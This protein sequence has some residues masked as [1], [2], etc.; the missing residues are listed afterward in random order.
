M[1]C[2]PVLAA[3]AA[4]C[5]RP[6]PG[7]PAALPADPGLLRGGLAVSWTAHGLT[8]QVLPGWTCGANQDDFL[9]T[10]RAAPTVTARV[11]VE[12]LLGPIE[13]ALHA[14]RFAG[15]DRAD[16]YTLTVDGMQGTLGIDHIPDK[17]EGF[18]CVFWT[19]SSSRRA[20]SASLCGMHTDPP[21][22]R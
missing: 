5:S 11:R 7:L 16:R 9:C 1:V 4:G 13:A 10:D 21:S 14:D 20:R 6:D 8:W 17:A 22:R 3:L 15:D 12:P 19:G 18:H 2:L